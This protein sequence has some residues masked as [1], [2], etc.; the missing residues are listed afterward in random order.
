[1]RGSGWPLSKKFKASRVEGPRLKDLDSLGL[2][3]PLF[4]PAVGGFHGVLNSHRLTTLKIT[5]DWIVDR[6]IANH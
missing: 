6:G 5:E 1:M 4:A 3:D 2:V